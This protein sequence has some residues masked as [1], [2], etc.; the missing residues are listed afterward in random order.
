MLP[1]MCV[2]AI[3]RISPNRAARRG[4]RSCEQ[5]PSTPAAKKTAPVVAGGQ[6]EPQVQ[7]QHEQRR[8]DEAAAGRVEA[9]QRGEAETTGRDGPSGR[10]GAVAV[11]STAGES[12]R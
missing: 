9:E 4:A 6:V 5:P 2:N 3:V 1:G 11:D 8:D 7:P 10:R 12:R